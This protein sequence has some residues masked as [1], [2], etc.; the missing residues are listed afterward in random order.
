MEGTVVTCVKTADD[1]ARLPH[2][3]AS[4]SLNPDA[5]R[6]QVALYR[7]IMYGSSGLSRAERE[8]IAVCVSV[9]NECHY[10]VV[11]HGAALERESGS[12]ALTEAVASA[13]LE[14][15]PARTAALCRYALKLTRRPWEMKAA[16]IQAL[17]RA[18]CSDRD[19][20]DANQAASYFN[21]VN[22][23]ADGLGVELEDDWPEDVRRPPRYGIAD[24][25]A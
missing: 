9:A 5:L 14:T 11:Q 3:L 21:Y 12:A 17:R 6:A 15:L 1:D 2:V 13:N 18:G 4:H 8:A 25:A 19:V 23:V 22:R 7:T 16:D 24:G 20:V 10:W